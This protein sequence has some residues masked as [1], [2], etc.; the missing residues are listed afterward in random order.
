MRRDRERCPPAQTQAIAAAA[1]ANPA[2][3]SEL[4][5]AAPKLT[6]GQLRERC[7]KA[8]ADADPDPSERHNRLR[9][10]RRARRYATADGFHHLHLQSTAE[11]LAEVDVTL[12]PIVD[13]LF[14]AARKAGR[15]EGREAY[16]ADAVIE[17]A[18]RARG[19]IGAKRS[20]T[21]TAVIRADLSALVAGRASGDE[22]CE[23]AG[24]GPVPVEI[25]RRLLGDSVLRL[26]LTNGVDVRSVTSLG[27]GPTAAQKIALLWEQPT[28]S[29]E[30]CGRRARLEADHT[31][32]AEFTRTK[33]TR[34]DELDRLCEQHHDKKTHDGWGLV[35]GTGVRPMV[36]PEDRRHPKHGAS[37]RA[38]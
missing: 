7:A 32:G 5:A 11:D 9:R 16:L 23:I 38:P 20:S 29:V 33:H 19:A 4:L 8:I 25:V 26:V 3:E 12:N 14:A 30:H 2:A 1:T 10:G 13:E 24:I 34:L 22:V 18:R 31:T 37:T 15:R 35:P 6:L 36:P 27:R 17:M 28:C 21:Y